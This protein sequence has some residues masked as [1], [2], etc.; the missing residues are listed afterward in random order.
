MEYFIK[1]AGLSDIRMHAANERGQL[2]I[3]YVD[4]TGYHLYIGFSLKKQISASEDHTAGKKY[5]TF[6]NRLVAVSQ[7][8]QAQ[9]GAVLLEVQ[10]DK[11]HFL[12][13]GSTERSGSVLEFCRG[14]QASVDAFPLYMNENLNSMRYAATHGRSIL[15]STGMNPD[16]STVSLGPAANDPAKKLLDVESGHLYYRV[17]PDGAKWQKENLRSVT[18][19]ANKEGALLE[20]LAANEQEPLD[21]EIR[22][23][24]ELPSASVDNPYVMQGFYFRSDLDGFTARVK[25]S[26]KDESGKMV[27]RLVSDFVEI[28]HYAESY[29]HMGSRLY[30]VAK[31]PWSG[32]CANL[33]IK[34]E[35]SYSLSRKTVPPIS[36][37][38]WFELRDKQNDRSGYLW[39]S[40]MGEAG[41]L[42]SIAGGGP[43]TEQGG[44]GALLI[45]DIQTTERP[46][47]IAA[48]WGAERSLNA[49]AAKRVLTN[50]TVLQYTDYLALD[51]YYKRQFSVCSENSSYYRAKYP[52]I[53]YK[54]PPHAKA[55]PTSITTSNV[56]TPRPA[57]SYDT[58]KK[59]TF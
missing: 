22:S 12:F 1:N 19:I 30:K 9:H 36:S 55:I 38:D 37:R 39:K 17:N 4:T 15:I 14:V 28:M 16:D 49:Q 58:T 34:A 35:E 23:A 41:W 29:L 32:D 54:V 40:Y 31:L 47:R 20:S 45:A 3:N 56:Y 24:L 2:P 43:N 52:I 50:D 44:N 11:I 59:K 25:E 18:R 13:P 57:S 7:G 33:L 5:I 53:S 6:L 46:F 26:F 8:L 27:E 48:G 10:S 42:V 21:F 51:K